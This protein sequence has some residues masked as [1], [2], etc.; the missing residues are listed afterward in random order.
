M[1]SARKLATYDDL[2]ALPD[3]ARAE[4][5][6][7]AIV[8]LPAPLPRHSNVQGALRRF[9]GGPFH[10]DDGFGG[11]G[12][13][14]IFLE[15]DVRLDRHDVARPDLAG[16]RR[17]RLPAP[18]DQRPIDVVPDWICEVVS[19]S[20]ERHDRVTK[21]RLYAAAGVAHYWLVDPDERVLEA[22]ALES[23][24]WRVLGR[25]LDGETARVAPFDAI[26]LDVTRLFPPID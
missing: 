17:A 14:W 22:L 7:G 18:W 6:R 23:G 3:D 11:P 19:P 9:V 20:N 26:E 16:W 25:W 2:L 13:W 15:V 12:G 1:D 5:I 8:T 24:T 10:D 21:M 4:I